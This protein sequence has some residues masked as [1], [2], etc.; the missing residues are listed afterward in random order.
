MPNIPQSFST[1]SGYLTYEPNNK[2]KQFEAK[3]RLTGVAAE[4]PVQSGEAV[5]DNE[6]S[7]FDENGV[8]TA[9]GTI[10]LKGCAD[11]VLGD[12]LPRILSGLGV[13]RQFK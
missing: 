13:A 7:P 10:T 2:E 6:G 3:T 5:F 9:K 11:V 1:W 8:A 4:S 12:Y